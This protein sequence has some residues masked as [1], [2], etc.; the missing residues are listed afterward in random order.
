M[1]PE[2]DWLVIGGGLHGVHLAVRL[3]AEAG[4]APDGLRLLDPAPRL[5]ARWGQCTA[6]T[7]MRHLRSPAVHHL[8]VEPLSLLQFAGATA[9]G[10]ELDDE[11][12][13]PPY[14]RPSLDLFARHSQAVIARHGLDGLHIQAR[15]ERV[16][17][18]GDGARVHLD[19]GN[20][21]TARRVLLA[22]GASQQPRWPAWAI[23]LRDGGV[24][25]Q[26]VFEPG[27]DLVPDR[28]PARLAVIGGGI[29]AA[30]VALRL[31]DAA[32][33]VHLISRHAVR[34][35]AFD[36]DPGWVGPKYMRGFTATKSLRAR[37]EAITGA[38]HTG[39]MPPD[40]HRALQAAVGAGRITMHVGPVRARAR[41]HR[42]EVVVGDTPLEV[43]GV[44]LA[45]GFDGA[46][47]GGALVD[48]LVHDHHLPCA[49]CG[50]PIVD[51]HLRWHDALCVT[52][53]LAE[54]E[55]GPVARNI[56]GARRAAERIVPLALA[57]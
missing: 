37:R 13:T 30:Q 26:H 33:V 43:D 38:R 52:G 36:S 3:L 16:E 18:F 49:A 1:R 12:F 54:L 5:L 46:R 50:Y 42:A 19:S 51:R 20:A 14:N 55:V 23:D 45:T 44:L 41:G 22:L 2:L 6:N 15:A 11:Q 40:V 21:L 47:P 4:V 32:R 8:D 10:G 53:P 25:I 24:A 39:S 29:S 31:A 17:L 27:F 56:A 34:E 9:H 35:H 48:A 7:G 57:G 28:W